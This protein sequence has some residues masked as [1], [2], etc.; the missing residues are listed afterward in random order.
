MAAEFSA[1]SA[2][3]VWVEPAG[4]LAPGPWAEGLSLFGLAALAWVLTYALHSTLFL[5]SAWLFTRRLATGRAGQ[6]E[7]V[8][9]FA[10]L[11]SFAT[12]TLQVGL[13]F[14]PLGGRL[15]LTRDFAAVQESPAG[16]GHTEGADFPFHVESDFGAGSGAGF[17][18][19]EPVDS[20]PGR[21]HGFA[22]PGDGAAAALDLHFA[23]AA[24]P[25]AA[26]LR[27]GTEWTRRAVQRVVEQAAGAAGSLLAQA[28][29]PRA[30]EALASGSFTSQGDEPGRPWSFQNGGDEGL[31]AD[32]T[33]SSGS[34][35]AAD[36]G[37]LSSLS[38]ALGG[39]QWQR[40]ALASL[41]LG[42]LGGVILF[43]LLWVR[44]NGCLRDRVALEHGAMADK[45]R[46]LCLQVGWKRRVRLSVAPS[47]GAPIS[48]GMFRPEICVPPRALLEL[49]LE[50]QEALLAH[51]LAHVVR[52]DPLWLAFCRLCEGVFFFQ[53]MNRV[54]RRE[55]ED[56]AEFLSDAWAVRQTGL[57]FSLASCLT[58]IAEWIVG[59]RRVHPA[60]A[61]AQ[62]RSRLRHRVELL[63]DEG[64][65]SMIERRPAWLAPACAGFG[66]ALI[67]VV[68]CVSAREPRLSVGDGGGLSFLPARGA[69]ETPRDE[70][71]PK[72][73]SFE[74][75]VDGIAAE[76]ERRSAEGEE[77]PA[78]FP[79]PC[80]EDAESLAQDD[81][82][83]SEKTS[84]EASADAPAASSAFEALSTELDLL[85]QDLAVLRA[86]TWGLGADSKVAR[87][88]EGELKL[89]EMKL[90]RLREL[91]ARLE[92]VRAQNSP[93]AE[94]LAGSPSPARTD[95][96]TPR[97]KPQVSK[98]LST[99]VE[100]SR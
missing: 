45:L 72:P 54:A 43:A 42:A 14:E 52:R 55:L 70:W 49:S 78:E 1:F 97:S 93:A 7:R 65:A 28:E 41:A 35:S 34:E 91:G 19:G 98:T 61:M 74:F 64:S 81:G 32:R 11:A 57:R 71:R 6:R 76:S 8:W 84:G 92:F 30:E 31:P 51:E 100:T 26:V 67:A 13:G 60:P 29:S 20:A 77:Y 87:E 27:Q 63:L 96:S 56:C 90:A 16:P 9:K 39:R 88:I 53:P 89:L 73:V 75:E 17:G 21:G 24:T 2:L 46:S 94:V 95:N 47:L 33:P 79:E 62:G 50:E 23:S 66:A 40:W 59:D 4:W 86:E 25:W 12:A 48:M 36:G 83:C 69:S 22:R 15:A 3:A 5:S 68:P 18:H 99:S 58:R 85:A 38:A 82:L 80:L 44:L 37:W 10:M